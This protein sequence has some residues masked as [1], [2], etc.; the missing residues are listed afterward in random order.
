M[1]LKNPPSPSPVTHIPSTHTNETS[2]A[3]RTVRRYNSPSPIKTCRVAAKPENRATCGSIRWAIQVIGSAITPG[4]PC[5]LGRI[6]PVMNVLPN[7]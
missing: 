6:T 2:N 3:G 7:M 1:S 5:A 4:W